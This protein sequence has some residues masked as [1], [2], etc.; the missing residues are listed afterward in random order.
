MYKGSCLKKQV[1]LELNVHIVVG[2]CI[3]LLYFCFSEWIYHQC[4]Q[5]Y[6][7][8]YNIFRLSKKA[9]LRAKIRG[10]N[11]K[12]CSLLS[13]IWKVTPGNK[14][15]VLKY[16]DSYEKCSPNI[17]TSL[18]SRHKRELYQLYLFPPLKLV[19]AR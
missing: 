16:W 10:T 8:C 4:V 6:K 15:Y 18:L 12:Y 2:I 14:L 5:C 9:Y 17:S 7:F 13:K 1:W 19:T 3:G 11:V